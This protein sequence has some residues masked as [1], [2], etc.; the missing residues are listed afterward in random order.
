MVRCGGKVGKVGKVARYLEQWAECIGGEQ[1]EPAGRR[2]AGTRETKQEGRKGGRAER[3]E[4]AVNW[5]ELG[6][7]LGWKWALS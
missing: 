7:D 5:G 3:E 2:G 4:L 6:R 1:G